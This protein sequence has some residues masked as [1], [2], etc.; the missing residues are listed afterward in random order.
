[1]GYVSRDHAAVGTE[2]AIDIR[3]TFEPA[4]IVKLPFYRRKKK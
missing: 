3:G 4:R 2:L 1:M